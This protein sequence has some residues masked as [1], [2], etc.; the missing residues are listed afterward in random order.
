M[1]IKKSLRADLE[2]KKSIFMQIG[3][4]IALAIVLVAFEWTSSTRAIDQSTMI[5]EGVVEEE[6]IPITRAEE[7]KTPPPPPPKA[8]DVLTIV[9]DDVKVADVEIIDSESDDNTTVE[10]VKIEQ[11]ATVEE[12]MEDA[13]VF[14]LVEEMPEFPGG[15]AAITKFIGENTKYPAIAVENGIQGKVYVSFVVNAKGKVENVKIVRGVD[16]SLDKEAVRV[17]ESMPM[18]KP[19]KQRNKPVKVSY[20]MPVTFKLQQQ[21]YKI[22]YL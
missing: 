2:N 10:V 8:L 6:I 7:V 18:W 16:P 19:G 11:T 17:I 1:D 4:I 14:V 22:N 12:E 9:D 13:P 20:T 15:P 3:L 5:S 21:F